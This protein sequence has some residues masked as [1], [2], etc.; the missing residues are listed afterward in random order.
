M[1]VSSKRLMENMKA[2]DYIRLSTTEGEKRAA[3]AIAQKVREMGGEPEFQVFKA[4]HYE[5]EK[6]SF[7]VI[8]PFYKS[9]TVTGYGF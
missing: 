7:E 3:E 5:I 6:V 9:Y 2:L 8:E 1:S 4:P